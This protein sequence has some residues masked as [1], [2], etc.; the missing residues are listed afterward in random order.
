MLDWRGRELA[1]FREPGVPGI[2]RREELALTEI[3]V[4]PRQAPA[5]VVG[6]DVRD[7]PA[8]GALPAGIAVERSLD[9]GEIADGDRAVH[10]AIA[11]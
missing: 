9:L 10:Q 11:S 3:E 1:L 7:W 2:R 8:A 5:D 4:E 6:P